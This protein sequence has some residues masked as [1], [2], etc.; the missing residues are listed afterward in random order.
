VIC[1]PLELPPPIGTGAC[2]ALTAS[3]LLSQL[4][5]KDLR[6]CPGSNERGLT[7]DQLTQGGTLDCDPN[8]V[9]LGP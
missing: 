4:G 9:P 7:N 5:I 2:S 6:R 1:G 8:Q 3:G